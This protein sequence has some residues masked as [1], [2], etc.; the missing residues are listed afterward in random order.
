MQ[1]RWFLFLFLFSGLAGAQVAPAGQK[2]SGAAPKSSVE[3]EDEKDRPQPPSAAGQKDE[4]EDEQE[5]APAASGAAAQSKVPP[6]TPVI[7]VEGLC[8]PGAAG[9]AGAQSKTTAGAKPG[10]KTVVTRAEFDQLAETLNVAPPMRRQLATAY[11]RL[12]LFA[13]QAKKEGLDKEPHYREMMRFASLQIL[14]QDFTRAV[15][16][17][18]ANIPEADLEQYYKNN[19]AKFQQADLQRIF[20]PRTKQHEPPPAN[21]SSQKPDTAAEEAA[22]KDLAE[23]LHQRAVAG[24]DFTKL[25]KEA[26]QAAGLKAAEPTVSLGKITRGNLPGTH[27]KVFDLK[28]GQ[29]SELIADPGGYY[30]YKSVSQQEIPFAQAKA[31]IRTTLQAQRMQERME[32]LINSIHPQLNPEYFGGEGS[33]AQAPGAGARTQPRVPAHPPQPGA[34]PDEDEKPKAPPQS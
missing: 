7:T 20:I 18:A 12:L 14:A 3:L 27:E 9:S 13:E 28:P 11:P 19:Q 15:Q 29:V 34:K 22:M 6:N 30:V 26:F 25:Q 32:S 1:F 5:E 10:C 17:N 16:K 31:E 21:A 8:A 4:D 23:K 24:E 33:G 2:P